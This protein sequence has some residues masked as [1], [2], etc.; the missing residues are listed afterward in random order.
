VPVLVAADTH[1][2]GR[3]FTIDA[4]TAD[5]YWAEADR[6]LS[7]PPDRQERDRVRE[8]ARRYA[9]L[10]FFRFHNVLGAVTEDGRSSPRIRAVQAS[11]LDPGSDPALDRV[12][13]GILNGT[14]TVAP[15]GSRP[16]GAVF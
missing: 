10:L 11:D 9:V 7:D 3:G 12:V 13:D 14:S 2:R 16:E 4:N 8:L 6:T 15:R 1:Y 5:A